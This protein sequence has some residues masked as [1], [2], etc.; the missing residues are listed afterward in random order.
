[1][2]MDHEQEQSR[3]DSVPRWANGLSDEQWVRLNDLLYDGW[4]APEILRE[5]ALP[6]SLQRSLRRHANKF[7][8]RRR[9]M[10]FAAFKDSLL[11]AAV[12]IGPELQHALKLAAE[13]AVSP[14]VPPA[15]Q[16]RAMQM[17]TEFAKTVTSSMRGDEE[18]EQKRAEAEVG[19]ATGIDPK[20]ALARIL[21]SYGI[22]SKVEG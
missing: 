7:A 10:K 13:Y 21:D 8:P 9:L 4:E 5:L 12:S 20:E 19:Q 16:M 1:M 17:M 22:K 11:S 18:A 6:E 2:T 3:I 14:D 15:T